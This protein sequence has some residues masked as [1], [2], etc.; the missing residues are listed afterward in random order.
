MDCFVVSILDYERSFCM[1]ISL[2]DTVS[3]DNSTMLVSLTCA[4]L[5]ER[6][7]P[8]FVIDL[9]TSKKIAEIKVKEKRLDLRPEVTALSD[10]GKILYLLCSPDNEHITAFKTRTG[11]EL[12]RIKFQSGRIEGGND[13]AD[14]VRFLCM[15]L[16]K[17]YIVAL[18]SCYEKI[19]THYDFQFRVVCFDRNTG[20]TVASCQGGLCHKITVSQNGNRVMGMTH[21]T[22]EGAKALELWDLSGLKEN[23]MQ[24]LGKFLPETDLRFIHMTTD[25]RCVVTGIAGTEELVF[26]RMC[27]D[28]PRLERPENWTEKTIVYTAAQ[29]VK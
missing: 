23:R 28:E 3:K 24:F 6:T 4:S 5:T 7:M 11:K 15:E 25:E 1:R 21:P 18:L 9:K 17:D 12:R 26:L 16:H 29:N 2:Y 8:I 20:V 10:D 19:G 22:G 27:G 14:K 13:L